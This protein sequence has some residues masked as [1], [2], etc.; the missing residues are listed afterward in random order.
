M[1]IFDDATHTYRLD[2]DEYISA[3][4]LLKKYGITPDYS[5]VPKDVLEKAANRGKAVH[6]SIEL[7]LQGQTN[8]RSMYPEVELVGNY[9]DVRG[10]DMATVKSEAIIYDT[11]YKIAG[12]VDFQ[13]V[14]DSQLVI[15]DFKTTY[16][17]HIDAVMW[18]LSIYN[19][20]IAQGDVTQYYFNKLKVFH[21]RDN[22]MTIKDVPLVEYDI[23]V[24]L[25]EAHKNNEATFVPVPID[26]LVTKSE[27]EL[28]KNI[29]AEMEMFQDSLDALQKQYDVVLDK[30]KERLLNANTKKVVTRE[31]TVDYSAPQTRTSLDTE[32]VKK[33]LKQNNME[34]AFTKT[35]TTKDGVR[36]KFPSRSIR[37]FISNTD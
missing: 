17:L 10:I 30:V 9:I 4:T 16:N 11:N 26:E 21:I 19:Y 23:L 7:Y 35:T 24:K 36:V 28:I 14:E 8:L 22:K 34:D 12:T 15:A 5:T 27:Q 2:S 6:K 32:A 1:I 29:H 20:M 18:Q 33:Y 31:F 3:T 13:Y 25:F 37:R